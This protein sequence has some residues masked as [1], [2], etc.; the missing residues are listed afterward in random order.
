M[1]SRIVRLVEQQGPQAG[2]E[3]RVALGDEPLA[4]WKACMLSPDLVV[5][6]V[7]TRYL[8]LEAMEAAAVSAR[9]EAEATLLATDQAV[10]EGEELYLFYTADESEEFG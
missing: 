1:D 8:R 9:A 2:A 10:P 3:M 7:G 4:Q 6:R 5:R